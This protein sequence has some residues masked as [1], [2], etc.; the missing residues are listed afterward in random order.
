MNRV[1]A[2][3]EIRREVANCTQ[4]DLHYSRINAVPGEGPSD[5]KVMF[6]GEGPGFH[7]NQKGKPF[8][9]AAGEFLNELLKKASL[10]RDKVFITNIVKCRPPGNR[11]PQIGELNA[12][13]VFLDRQIALINPLIIVTLGRY[14]MNRFFKSALISK[15]HGQAITVNDRLIVAM[16]HPA[17]ALHQPF[18]RNTVIE[19][20]EKLAV[21][22]KNAQEIVKNME[23]TNDIIEEVADSPPQQLSLF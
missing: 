16:Y 14:S 22:I 23:G 20:F 13:S 5:A 2:L 8:V 1:D 11:D 12:C 6:V 10:N 21:Y 4:C 7:E 15:V 18:L 9:G 19:D 3:N 17:A